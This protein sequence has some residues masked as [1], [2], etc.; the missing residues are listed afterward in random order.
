MTAEEQGQEF[1]VEPGRHHGRHTLRGLFTPERILLVGFALLIVLG[2]LLLSLPFAVRPGGETGFLTALFT[3]TSAV[4][5]T[6]LV[7]VD[8]ADN[9]S[10]FGHL[11]ILGLIKT[12]GLG[13]LTM[14]SLILIVMGRRI[15]LRQR[16]LLQESLNQAQVGGIVRLVVRIVVISVLIEAVF[17][18]VLASRFIDDFG[19]GRGLWMGLF[20]SVSAFNNA[21]FDLLGG[22]RSLT[23]Y[24]GDIVVNLGIAVPVIL[25]GLGF[26]VIVDL[27]RQ[28]G[29]HDLT[30]HSKVVLGATGLLLLFGTLI[31]LS[32][33]QN[34]TLAG[35]SG[36]DKVL[37]AFFQAM[38]PRTAGF[39]TVAT[40]TLDIST[41]FFLLALMFIGAGPNSVAG[42]IKVTTFA[43]LVL[44]TWNL[45][46]GREAIEISERQ[47]PQIMLLKA[48]ALTMIL[49]GLIFLT[50][51]LLSITEEADFLATL[52]ETTSAFGLVGLTLGLTPELSPVGKLIITV[53][54]FIGRVGPLTIAFALARPRKKPHIKYPE[55]NIV[56][57]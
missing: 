42:G 22:F 56:I 15:G 34:R 57:G 54:M 40:E 1:S 4:C 50:T 45:C 26:V 2:T 17:T 29:F 51:L 11:V 14:T 6:G 16:L 49:F 32:L 5:V 20:H 37:A 24:T 47:I 38:T 19:L 53:S 21:G 7:V 43:I 10:T 39:S 55:E 44:A 3:A 46:R 13:F 18:L 35:L 33:E 9:W 27:Y 48:L 12:G 25:G 8:T 30:L 23:P 36:P 28:R 52:F 41:L 31:I